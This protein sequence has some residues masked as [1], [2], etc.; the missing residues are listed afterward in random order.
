[1]PHQAVSQQMDVQGASWKSSIM[2]LKRTHSNSAET[3]Q[4][5][6]ACNVETDPVYLG[7]TEFGQVDK[8][9]VEA[10]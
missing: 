4:A 1:M 2:M 8:T 6:N 7:T 5:S 9:S 10:T 3:A